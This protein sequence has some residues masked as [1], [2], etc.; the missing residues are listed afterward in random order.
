MLLQKKYAAIKL[1]DYIESFSYYFSD[2]NQSNIYQYSMLPIGRVQLLFQYETFVAHK[3]IKSKK[4]QDRPNIFIAG[5]FTKSYEMKLNSSSRILAIT[6]RP[7]MFKYFSNIDISEI[8]NELINPKDIWGTIANE[9]LDILSQLNSIEQKIV[10]IEDFLVKLYNN[11][12]KSQ[13]SEILDYFFSFNK[14]VKISD[15]SKIA[16]LSESR[17]RNKFR[18][19]I[20]LSPKEYQKLIRINNL[21]K[22]FISE[23]TNLTNIAYRF[24][25]FD[26]SH[27]IKEFK[28]VTNQSPKIYFKNSR[29]LQF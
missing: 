16:N 2:N 17:F 22:M 11:K 27:F 23:R 10:A 20:G 1:Y 19:E 5:P 29:F 21:S 9:L 18:E 28:S 6:F 13:I 4:W 15:F 7:T 26:Q 12:K 24:G 14:N 8:K 25:Y 3:T